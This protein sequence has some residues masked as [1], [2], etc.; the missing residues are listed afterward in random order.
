MKIQFA[1]YPQVPCQAL[2][3]HH[4]P[5]DAVLTAACNSLSAVDNDT[6]CCFLLQTFKQCP[7]LM[8]TPADTDRRV[9]LSKPQSG[10]E[11]ASNPPAFC[12]RTKHTALRF[13]ARHLPVLFTRSMSC[14]DGLAI[15]QQTRIDANLR[16]RLVPSNRFVQQMLCPS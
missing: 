5:S 1:H 15:A 7:P 12:E 14:T 3:S 8:I 9:F 2:N 16:S 10:S 11:Y 6:T 13:P 4:N